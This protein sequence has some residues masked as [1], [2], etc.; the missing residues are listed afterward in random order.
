MSKKRCLNCRKIKP[1]SVGCKGLRAM[2]CQQCAD[3][4][5]WKTRA[6]KAKA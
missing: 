2:L 6:K 4:H 3:N 5:P 1:M